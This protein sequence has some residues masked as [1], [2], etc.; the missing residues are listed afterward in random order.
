MFKLTL[1]EALLV[2]TLSAVIAAW[3]KQSGDERTINRAL[4][5]S[6]QEARWKASSAESCAEHLHRTLKRVDERLKAEKPVKFFYP[7]YGN[8]RIYPTLMSDGYF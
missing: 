4:G 3:W 8:G 1:K 2:M 6:L 5:D 7:C